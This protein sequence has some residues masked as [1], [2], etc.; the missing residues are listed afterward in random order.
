MSVD[1][2]RQNVN[3]TVLDFM[4]LLTPYLLP[5]NPTGHYYS[6]IVLRQMYERELKGV[7]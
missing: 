7:S 3:H 1:L 5:F 2:F 4:K 6:V